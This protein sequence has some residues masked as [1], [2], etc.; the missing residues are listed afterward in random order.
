MPQLAELLASL[1]RV[2]SR[3]GAGV[4]LVSLRA[5]RRLLRHRRPDPGVLLPPL[6]TERDGAARLTLLLPNEFCARDLDSADQTRVYWRELA[7]AE[8]VRRHP[9]GAGLP[10]LPPHKLA[11]GRAALVG[12]FVISAEATD[13]VARERLAAWAAELAAFDPGEAGIVLPSC[14]AGDLT[15]LD[16]ADIAA[17]SRPDLAADGPRADDPEAPPAAP[18][19]GPTAGAL[20]EARRLCARRNFVRAL[21]VLERARAA[22]PAE[23]ELVAAI[24]RVLHDD[25][26]YQL[27]RSLRLGAEG[28]DRF[29]AVAAELT[30]FAARRGWSSARRLLFDLQSVALLAGRVGADGDGVG[31]AVAK[32]R[33][34]R[35]AADHAAGA[36]V[37]EALR[38][39]AREL[40]AAERRR[41]AHALQAR[42]AP[43]ITRSLADAGFADPAPAAEVARAAVA[44][45]LVDRLAEKG[46]LRIGDLRDCLTQSPEKLGDLAGV[47]EW[48]RGDGLLRADRLLAARLGGAYHRGEIYLRLIHR[49]QSAFFGTP[50][51][52]RLSLVL[53]LPCA[54]AFLAV[55]FAAYIKLEVQHVAGWVGRQLASTPHPTAELTQVALGAQDALAQAY[56]VAEPHGHGHHHGPTPGSLGLALALAV[57]LSVLINSPQA[58]QLA[59][60]AL[61]LA[62]WLLRQV[63]YAWPEAVWDSPP[64]RALR[65]NPWARGAWASFATAGVLAMCAYAVMVV[66][67]ADP[68]YRRP[69]AFALFA[70]V[71][72]FVRTRFGKRA[73]E[74]AYEILAEAGR[75]LRTNLIPG[76]VG[77][78]LDLFRWAGDRVERGLYRVDEFLR[79]REGQSRL[80]TGLKR[81]AGV[82][83][84][85]VAYVVRFAFLLLIEPQINPVKHFP[86]VTVSH[87]LLLPLIGTLAGATGLSLEA[88]GLIIAG[89]PG[90]FGFIV[91]ELRGNWGLYAANR[92]GALA[93]VALGHHGETMRRYLRPGFH[94]GT[95]PRLRARQRKQ[96]RAARNANRRFHPGGELDE[97]DHVAESVAH[98]VERDAL[99]LLNRHPAWRDGPL[100]V[101]EVR[102]GSRYAEADLARPGVA[103]PVGLVF[104]LRGDSVA[105]EVAR[106]GWLA[107]VPTDGCRALEV[108]L[109][110]IAAMAGAVLAD[111][112]S[113]CAAPPL[114]RAEWDEFWATQLAPANN[115]GESRE[116]PAGRV[117]RS[118]RIAGR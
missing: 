36:R 46:Y 13:A 47:V 29:A 4:R 61:R 63:F 69:L 74:R 8:V 6:W 60:D 107:E 9:G 21:V 104:W 76:A 51:G 19:A 103:E 102:L 18:D 33:G 53:L 55:E 12:D 88:A 44:A 52:R 20:A 89:I 80:A 59:R 101:A 48:M 78:I 22:R 14:R 65:G 27:Q 108:T 15:G 97:L 68:Y 1:D 10:E 7:Q 45:R 87:K 2:T 23:T 81:L 11:D 94:S 73:E 26:A 114:C 95:V 54:A 96:W 28:R 82:V 40:L 58:R 71:A 77:V 66:G 113:P 17:R 16:A 109:A 112:P 99:A 31:R 115:S 42:L 3:S 100:S 84:Y 62:G 85:P 43:L 72:L 24:R 56:P 83:W 5:W 30:P 32:L 118:A 92:S 64:L 50:L 38:T 39:A 98:F 105:L 70:L 35:L 34:L 116:R 86:V 75:E 110:A 117:G 106:P 111:S 93:P 91:W 90:I 37:P 49:L 67:G 41:Q 25:L 57:V 79:F